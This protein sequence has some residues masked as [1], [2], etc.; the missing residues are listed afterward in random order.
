MIT[1]TLPDEPLLE[2]IR[3][4]TEVEGELDSNL[5]DRFRVPSQIDMEAMLR[6]TMPT[7][8]ALVQVSR[9]LWHWATAALYRSIIVTHPRTL[10]LLFT[11]IMQ[12]GERCLL[13][14]HGVRRFHLSIPHEHHQCWRE[15]GPGTEGL[16]EYLPNLRIFCAMGWL[17]PTRPLLFTPLDPATRFPHLEAIE[18][19]KHHRIITVRASISN[20]LHSSPHLRVFL[21]TYHRDSGPNPDMYAFKYLQGCYTDDALMDS[22]HN[23][24]DTSPPALSSKM[25]F[26]RLRSLHF[27]R[28]S[29]INIH[30]TIARHITLLDLS[31]FGWGRET[32]LDLSR[33][34]HLR[35]LVIPSLPDWWRFQLSDKNEGLDEIG[36]RSGM[37]P[38]G[39]MLV[40]DFE[41][42]VE[43]VVGLP[44]MIQRL[45]VLE[46]GLCR[47]ILG[48]GIHE[49][50]MLRWR[51]ELEGRGIGLEG[52]NGRPLVEFVGSLSQ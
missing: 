35:T 39:A 47:A 41:E 24:E 16:M 14:R 38:P 46:F 15:V 11:S 29:Q 45:R 49:V 18:C 22:G 48:L 5:D 4:A 20:L 34:P 2:V 26:P 21:V 19:S 17:H 37:H 31:L 6:V 30:R 25:P 51:R 9:R 23:L 28:E 42:V 52:P 32:I 7:R 36:V 33:F 40:R 50:E 8:R 3:W 27:S 12:S 44:V 43:L 1:L 10:N 13:F